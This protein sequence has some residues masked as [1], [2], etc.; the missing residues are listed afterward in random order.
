MDSPARPTRTLIG[1]VPPQHR[2]L[3]WPLPPLLSWLLPALVAAACVFALAACGGS[4]DTSSASPGAAA[5]S[6]GGSGPATEARPTTHAGRVEGSDAYVAVRRLGGDVIA[7]ICDG[8]GIVQWFRGRTS[9]DRVSLTNARGAVLEASFG[10]SGFV[11]E[12]Q[13]AD[14]RLSFSAA[15]VQ[16]PAGLYRSEEQLGDTRRVGGWI[17]LPDGTQRGAVQTGTQTAPA[18]ALDPGTATAT[19]GGTTVQAAAANPTPPQ[20]CTATHSPATVRARSTTAPA[21]GS[22]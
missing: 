1:D 2:L 15:P 3:R 4:S 7:Y 20:P 21:A 17:V 5:S 6:P 22:R 9:G 8:D 16:A 19:V 14:R 10:G 18:P 12:V 11:G 13:L